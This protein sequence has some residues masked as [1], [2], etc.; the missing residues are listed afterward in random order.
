MEW[1][2]ET[3]VTV[4]NPTVLVIGVAASLALFSGLVARTIEAFEALPPLGRI[5]L[6]PMS[7]ARQDQSHGHT[8]AITPNSSP[9]AAAPSPPTGPALTSNAPTPHA[10]RTRRPRRNRQHHR[11]PV[12]DQAPPI[13]AGA[14]Q[15]IGRTHVS[16][17]TRKRR[18]A[19]RVRAIGASNTHW[20]VD[21]IPLL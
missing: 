4:V 7:T 16:F 21:V 11:H 20:P 3:V 17:D 5:P 2:I 14:S 9:P 10:S 18:T 19:D 13:P 8:L 6:P 1:L 12:R 15:L